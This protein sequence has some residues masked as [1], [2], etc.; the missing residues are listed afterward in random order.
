MG[1]AVFG[2]GVLRPGDADA[3]LVEI[4]RKRV[5]HKQISNEITDALCKQFYTPLEREAWPAVL[6]AAALRFWLSR[7]Y[8]LHLP[9]PGT[10]VH[11][12]D[13]EHFRRILE[14]RIAAPAPWMA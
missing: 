12:H 2:E 13:P 8:D 4:S 11:A 9:R 7:L 3:Q 1:A 5:A 10:L 6:R 14:S